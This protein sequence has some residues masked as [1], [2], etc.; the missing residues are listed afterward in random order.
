MIWVSQTFLSY[1]VPV[2]F[3]YQTQEEFFLTLYLTHTF[4]VH[5]LSLTLLHSHT[6]NPEGLPN[7]GWEPWRLFNLTDLLGKN[8]HI[9]QYK[10]LIVA[11]K[12]TFFQLSTSKHIM[13]SI[14]R[15][16]LTI[17]T[18]THLYTPR[19]LLT[20]WHSAAG[21]RFSNIILF[22]FTSFVFHQIHGFLLCLNLNGSRRIY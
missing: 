4:S 9:Q 15:I 6:H 18:Q 8:M 17:Y 19:H 2:F 5:L 21:V 16:N 20:F 22:C 3:N 12:S 11:S 10:L 1:W 13:A 14:F 7:A